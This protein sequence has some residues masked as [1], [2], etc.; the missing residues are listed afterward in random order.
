MISVDV[1]R[2]AMPRCPR[3]VEWSV[4]LSDAA[5][6]FAL[7]DPDE[8]AMLLAQIGHES[9]D[10]SR[11]VESLN[12]SAPRLKAVWPSRFA[13]IQAAEV[14][15]GKPEEL[16]N[17]VYAG[18]M[19]NGDSASGDGW[20]YRGRGPLQLTGRDGYA[21]FEQAT[22]WPVTVFPDLVAEDV[23]IGAASACWYWRKRVRMGSIQSVTRQINGGLHGLEDRIERFERAQ[24]AIESMV[25]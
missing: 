17:F 5:A 1:L 2:A 4:A 7:T 20:K 18:R 13:T 12:Y 6:F 21:A 11:L 15:A 14:F 3:P 22:G 25:G 16:A 23:R 9:A 8:V 10:L 24:A 19:G